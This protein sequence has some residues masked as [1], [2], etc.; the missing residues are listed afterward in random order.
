M[1]LLVIY[2]CI[3]MYVYTRCLRYHVTLYIMLECPPLTCLGILVGFYIFGTMTLH[4]ACSSLASLPGFWR[5]IG[6]PQ[7]RQFRLFLGIFSLIFVVSFPCFLVVWIR[8]RRSFS[9][10]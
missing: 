10:M 3:Y 9:L 1:F 4:M 5:Q 7:Q 2:T 6:L 8:I